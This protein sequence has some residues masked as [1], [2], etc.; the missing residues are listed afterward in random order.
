[1]TVNVTG[2]FLFSGYQSAMNEF[3][4]EAQEKVRTVIG[5]DL[6]VAKS[7]SHYAVVAEKVCNRVFDEMNAFCVGGVW[8]YEVAE[9]AGQWFILFVNDRGREPSDQ[10]WEQHIEGVTRKF[11]QANY[12]EE[13]VL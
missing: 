8:E 3:S 11:I 7:L 6:E 5:G 10:E 12:C 9:D 2:M 1:M 13:V 4:D